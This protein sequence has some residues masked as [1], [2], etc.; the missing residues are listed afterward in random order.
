M[1]AFMTARGC[2]GTATIIDFGK[3][4]RI[5]CLPGGVYI[6]IVSRVGHTPPM[7]VL[8]GHLPEQIVLS[9]PL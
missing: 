9:E 1:S 3:H 5:V 7:T 4:P 6:G 8:L 2:V